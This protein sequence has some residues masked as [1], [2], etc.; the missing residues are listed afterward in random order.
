MS[1]QKSSNSL[2][3]SISWYD[4][5]KDIFISLEGNVIPDGIKKERLKSKKSIFQ[6]GK[7][8]GTIWPEQMIL[9][10]ESRDC[11]ERLIAAVGEQL[12]TIPNGQKEYTTISES[13]K[14]ITFFCDIFDPEKPIGFMETQRRPD[15]LLKNA[16]R[17]NN[18]NNKSY[19]N[20]YIKLSQKIDH[21]LE[22]EE[23]HGILN[24]H[25]ISEILS[26]SDSVV[27][28]RSGSEKKKLR[29]FLSLPWIF[30]PELQNEESYC[31][32]NC[33]DRPQCQNNSIICWTLCDTN[34]KVCHSDYD[35]EDNDSFTNAI[36]TELEN[37]S[38]ISSSVGVNASFKKFID[39]LFNFEYED[40]DHNKKQYIDYLSHYIRLPVTGMSASKGEIWI[41]IDSPD[42][43][44][45]SIDG[46]VFDFLN[47]LSAALCVIPAAIIS[48]FSFRYAAIKEAETRRIYSEVAHLIGIESEMNSLLMKVDDLRGQANRIKKKI[49]PATTGIYTISS[50][51]FKLFSPGGGIQIN[52]SGFKDSDNE[53]DQYKKAENFLIEGIKQYNS[54][55]NSDDKQYLKWEP[56][57]KFSIS[58]YSGSQDSHKIKTVHS[59]DRTPKDLIRIWQDYSI[60]LYCFGVHRDLTLLCDIGILAKELL[61]GENEKG[62]RDKLLK[63]LF[64]YLKLITHRIRYPRYH[65]NNNKSIIEPRVF[66]IQ[67]TASI[68]EAMITGN[69]NLILQFG[70]STSQEWR[71]PVKE[72]VRKIVENHNIALP[73]SYT[74]TVFLYNNYWK[75]CIILSNGLRPVDLLTTLQGL[76]AEELGDNDIEDFDNRVIAEK[77][78]IETTSEEFLL[79]EITCKGYLQV[80]ELYFDDEADSHGLSGSIKSLTKLTNC[81][82]PS[83]LDISQLNRDDLGSLPNFSIVLDPK[84]NQKRTI[85]LL[86]FERRKIIPQKVR[87]NEKKRVKRNPM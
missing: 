5:I 25:K 69:K 12:S 38:D 64:Q 14:W 36:L 40:E 44:Y 49:A 80:N 52:F 78:L 16:E 21:I 65:P 22:S 81:R 59:Y 31:G 13:I 26:R 77:V 71:R 50:D 76:I 57:A 85:F 8:D 79:I 39:L 47:P 61:V 67:I 15:Y 45:K 54:N 83:I 62:K 86:K 19:V 51:F 53:K 55:T 60:L 2:E 37:N 74:K 3:N 17:S 28:V 70:D 72:I 29:D 33:D 24:G 58:D 73:D 48:E 11:V 42:E 75:K 4:C 23:K 82:M 6:E 41:A 7:K 63:R 18:D 66:D 43:G 84:K 1:Q 46:R 87:A 32:K 34:L 10:M 30:R 35:N 68:L 56:E 9:A 20:F 27:M